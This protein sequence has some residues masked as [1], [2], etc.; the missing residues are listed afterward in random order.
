MVVIRDRHLGR[1][2]DEI[3]E[4]VAGLGRLVAVADA[5]PQE[6]I[7]AAGHQ[8]QLQVAVDLHGHRRGQGVHVEEVDAVLDVV[9]DEHPLGV[10][11]DQRGGPSGVSWL[12]S[13]RVGSS[14][15]RSVMVNCRS[16]PS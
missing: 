1:G 8:R 16:G 2:V 4:Q 12:V 9:L 14:C 6:A 10:A 5:L 7:E 11:A 15:P 3:A 13:S